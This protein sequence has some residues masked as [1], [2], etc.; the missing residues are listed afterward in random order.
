[1]ATDQSCAL[2]RAQRH[3]AQRWLNATSETNKICVK[4]RFVFPFTADLL[5][6]PTHALLT[7]RSL[8]LLGCCAV[9]CCWRDGNKKQL[10][11]AEFSTHDDSIGDLWDLIVSGAVEEGSGLPDVDA[12]DP[13]PSEAGGPFVPIAGAASAKGKG[14]GR[15]VDGRW[16][17]SRLVLRMG[18]ASKETPRA[19]E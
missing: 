7:R 11:F 17:R 15:G 8:A 5:A 14:G 2:A 13:A 3:D 1:V 19:P 10:D 12:F 9:L 16:V 4:Y 18:V 6:E